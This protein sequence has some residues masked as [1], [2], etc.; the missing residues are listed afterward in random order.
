[1]IENESL[2]DGVCVAAAV[3]LGYMRQAPRIGLQ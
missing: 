2:L 3:S 1:M